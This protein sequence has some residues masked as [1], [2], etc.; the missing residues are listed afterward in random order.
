MNFEQAYNCIKVAGCNI[1]KE[2]GT[3]LDKTSSLMLKQGDTITI[4]GNMIVCQQQMP[5]GNIVE[6]FLAENQDG[7][8]KQVYAGWF[9]RLD[10]DC[11]VAKA[12]EP[13]ADLTT[14][15]HNME[16]RKICIKW[17]TNKEDK[18]R[19]KTF[20]MEFVD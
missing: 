14:F 5:A 20:T 19:C 12:L 3:P 6:F 1:T 17:T 7:Q 9:N 4:P 10:K 16:N 11:S 15:M 13:F 8:I 18:F 2:F